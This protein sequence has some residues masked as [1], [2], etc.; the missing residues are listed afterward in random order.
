MAADPNLANAPM[1]AQ[2]LERAAAQLDS[3]LRQPGIAERLRTHPGEGEWSVMQI[4]G[5]LAE[6]V[7]YWL[8][9][10]R[11]LITA[12]DQPPVIGRDMDA[13]QRLVGVEL[14]AAA[15]LDELL[16]RVEGEILDAA[17]TIRQMPPAD[18]LRQG[19]HA[20][21]GPLTVAQVIE[22]FI[23]AHAEEHLAQIQAA[24]RE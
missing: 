6:S 17:Q 7:P 12:A 24:L 2:R 22:K 9:S 11:K 4:L 10:C 15:Q 8:D 18:R 21:Y 3:L 16:P 13:P 14:G 19:I 20:R 23:V 5:H 1:H